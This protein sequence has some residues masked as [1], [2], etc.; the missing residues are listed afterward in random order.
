MVCYPGRNHELHWF[1]AAFNQRCGG[2]SHTAL[3]VVLGIV[4]LIWVCVSVGC[5]WNHSPF[6]FC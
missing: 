3:P 2:V 6:F 4:G 5:S 1:T